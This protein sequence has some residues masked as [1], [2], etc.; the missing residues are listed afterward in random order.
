MHPVSAA[1]PSQ[2][3]FFASFWPHSVQPGFSTMSQAFQRRPRRATS[4]S[5]EGHRVSQ[6]TID[7]MEALRRSGITFKEIGH[8]LGCSERT[9]RRYAGKVRPELHLPNAAPRLSTDARSIRE[10]LLDRYLRLLHDDPRLQ[11]LT[12]VWRDT[13]PD[14][15]ECTWGGPPSILFLNE[16]ERLLR[17]RLDTLG[18]VSLRLLAENR[19][20]QARFAREVIGELC[21]DYIGWHTFHDA[22]DPDG[23]QDSWRPPRE[24]PRIEVDEDGNP[25]GFPED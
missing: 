25:I 16:A 24:R 18:A 8:R 9:A 17:E 14:T 3:R 22:F 5:S 21:A 23:A 19:Q 12:R 6:E 7:K 4:R 10:R 15:K 13:G 20:T 2:F 11:D 1:R